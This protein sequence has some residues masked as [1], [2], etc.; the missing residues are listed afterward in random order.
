MYLVWYDDSPKK[1]VQEKIDEAIDRF[2]D[3]FGFAPDQCLVSDGLDVQHPH[4]TVRPVRYVRP[5]YFQVGCEDD[6][7]AVLSA[8]KDENVAP[9]VPVLVGEEPRGGRRR[10][11]PAAPVAP[12][13]HVPV[14]EAVAAPV[15]TEPVVDEPLVPVVPAVDEP[16]VAEVPALESPAPVVAEPVAEAPKPVR[17]RRVAPV[18]GTPAVEAPKPRQKASA[19][20]AETPA[21]EEVVKTKQKAAALVPETAAVEAPKPARKASAVEAETPAVESPKPVR[22]RKAVAPAAE[23]VV[24]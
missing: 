11:L 5:H 19:A 20:V 2:Q 16:A 22:T 14:V 3:R 12:K 13:K 23:P 8:H 7:M 10:S 21:A 17:T 9:L 6:V 1:S 4:L 15:A 18:A 24:E